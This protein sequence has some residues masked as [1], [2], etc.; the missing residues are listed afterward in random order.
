MLLRNRKKNDLNEGKWIGIGGKVEE[1]ELPE[2]CLLREVMEETGITLNSFH[3]YGV[4]HFRS[5]T[6]NEDMYLYSSDDFSLP[7]GCDTDVEAY[8]NSFDCSEGELAWIDEDR[9]SELNLWEGDRIFLEKM[10]RGD[11][12]FEMTL[13]YSGDK[14]ADVRIHTDEKNLRGMFDGYTSSDESYFRN[15]SVLVPVISGKEGLAILYEIR[16]SN[17]ER[18]PGEVCF[19]GG[20][21]EKGESPLSCAVRE[22]YE[23]IGIPEED[24]D[25]LC[26]LGSVYLPGTSLMHAFLA[27][28]PEDALEKLR[29]QPAEVSEVFMVSVDELLNTEPD[30]YMNEVNIVPDPDFPCKKVT[31]RDSYPWRTGKV[32]VPVYEVVCS[33]SKKRIIWG[34]TARITKEFSEAVRSKIG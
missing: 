26:E 31:G 23:E 25:V 8:I 7:E 29:L 19:P 21:I 10:I 14:L 13:L 11:E 6:D 24:I 17:M 9:I 30:V 3:F 12:H 28:I 34:L 33:D 15:Y 20:M 2:E 1:G 27:V 18:Q 16:D 4:V 5:D 22:T 32:P